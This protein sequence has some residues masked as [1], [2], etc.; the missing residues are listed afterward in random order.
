MIAMIQAPEQS[1][2]N[3]LSMFVQ[4]MGVGVLVGAALG[5]L[6]HKLFAALFF[7]HALTMYYGEPFTHTGA[8]AS[9]TGVEGLDVSLL[10][11]DKTWD[12]KPDGYAKYKP[13]EQ[14]IKIPFAADEPGAPGAGGGGT[15]GQ[16]LNLSAPIWHLRQRLHGLIA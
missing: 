16:R 8:V 12:F 10:Q 4:Q 5:H 2:V 1:A 14:E 6:L 13:F 9:Y 11:P 15:N 7:S 3:L